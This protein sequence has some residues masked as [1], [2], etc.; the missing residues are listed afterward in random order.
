MKTNNKKISGLISVITG[1][2]VLLLAVAAFWLSFNALRALASENG[3]S[4]N[5]AWV[6]PLIV[7]GA[8]IVFSLS[9]LRSSLYQERVPW[10]WFM[11]GLFT[12]S[13]IVFNILHSADGL[14]SGV[15]AAVAPIA[16]F[17]GFETLM[18]QVKN[19][20]ERQSSLQ[21]LEQITAKIAQAEAQLD[22]ILSERQGRIDKLDE[23]LERRRQSLDDINQSLRELRKE[24]R[25][26]D[27]ALADVPP[28]VDKNL[29]KLERIEIVLSAFAKDPTKSIGDLADHL[30]VSD[31][32]VRNYLRELEE[33]SMVVWDRN[34]GTVTVLSSNGHGREKVSV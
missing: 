15:I 1:I 23:S 18:R 22:K 12:V 32:T 34:G 4:P 33:T 17:L 30:S 20:V 25:E 21:S 19:E 16:L 26:L 9:I 27:Q 10:L 11:V 24:K 5:N 31:E 8:M 29:S 14:L 28:K 6:F 3:I 7:D 2:L 13:S